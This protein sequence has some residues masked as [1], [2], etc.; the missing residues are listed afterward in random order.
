MNNAEK[1]TTAL[2]MLF[3]S[4]LKIYKEVTIKIWLE[5]LLKYPLNEVLE[6]IDTIVNNSDDFI[7]LGKIITQI[8]GN[9]DIEAGE[10]WAK[11]DNLSRAGKL[12][13]KLSVKTA[14][15]L[16]L[17]GGL[18]RVENATASNMPFLKKEF[19]NIY[20]NLN[21]DKVPGEF[22]CLGLPKEMIEKTTVM[23]IGTNEAQL[24]IIKSV[25]S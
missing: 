20:K 5:R 21:K 6:A 17:I 4:K 10:Q 2:I 14:Y 18:R 1:I 25:V 8:S 15:C 13:D 9:H 19:I 12:K 11:I 7:T 24:K 22:N 23:I 3:E 16:K